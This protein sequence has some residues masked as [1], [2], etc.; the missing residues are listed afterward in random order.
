MAVNL[1]RLK[2]HLRIDYGDEDDVLAVYLGAAQAWTLN[3]TR[4]EEVPAGAE[5]EFDAAT[6]LQ[7]ASLYENR[8]ADIIGATFVETK[9]ATRM[10]DPYR[11]MSV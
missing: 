2:R 6:L 4:R 1:E 10:I 11:R 9:A 8:E 7:A 5:F 3:Y